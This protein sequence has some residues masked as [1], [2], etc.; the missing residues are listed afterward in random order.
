MPV[1]DL[2]VRRGDGGGGDA[3]ISNWEWLGPGNIGGRVRALLI[4]PGDPDILWAGSAG[5]GIWK[6][7]NG[8]NSWAPLNDFLPSIAVG[9][10]A[11]DPN[12]P[13]VLYA[14][15]G[16]SF[17]GDGLPGAGVF[18]SADGG[19]TWVQLAATAPPVVVPPPL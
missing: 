11:L 9:C 4:H 15:T 3:G 12:D 8:G 5:G 14:G 17:A 1:L 2:G 19:V 16:E 18:K 7:T 6:T 10:M 13:D